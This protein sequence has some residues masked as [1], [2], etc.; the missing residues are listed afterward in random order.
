MRRRPNQPMDIEL[1]LYALLAAVDVFSAT[2]AAVLVLVSLY[3]LALAKLQV[4]WAWQERHCSPCPF[5]AYLS[6]TCSRLL[7][8]LLQP[9]RA[10]R[11]TNVSGSP[12][13]TAP[14]RAP[15]HV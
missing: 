14:V 15:L 3:W 8:T 5:P 2:L 13:C 4:R 11:V 10:G 6:R 1:V 12:E 7:T 9:H